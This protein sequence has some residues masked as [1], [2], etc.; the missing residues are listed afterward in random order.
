MREA[1][2]RKSFGWFMLL[3]RVVMRSGHCPEGNSICAMAETTC[4]AAERASATCDCNV[5]KVCKVC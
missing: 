5:C 3:R 1:C 2:L 4:A